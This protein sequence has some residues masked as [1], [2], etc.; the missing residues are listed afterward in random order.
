MHMARELAKMLIDAKGEID[1][2]K[3]FKAIQ[4]LE[5]NLYSLGTNRH[6]DGPFQ[7]HMLKI[8]QLFYS[9]P[10]SVNALKRICRPLNHPTAE[11]LIRETLVLQETAPLNDAHARQAA[12]SALLSRLRQNVG[13]CF[14]TAPAILIQQ[15]QPLR[16]LADIA[17]LFGTGRLNRIFE[18][19][20][21]AV[22]LSVSSGVGDLFR[23]LFLTTLGKNPFK[24]LSLSLGLQAA[25]ESAGLID[26]KV[27]YASKQK[28]CEALLKSAHFARFEEDPFS[29]ITVDGILKAVLQKNF[30]INE[31]DIAHYQEKFIQGPF[32][33]VVIQA[34]LT[35]SGKSLACSRY[36]K[37]YDAAKWAFKAL[38]DN[39][40]LKAW[41]FS[42][43][44]LSESKADF[45]KWNLYISLGVQPEDL[46]GIG[47]SLYEVI[48]GKIQE[49]NEELNEI[50]SRYD[51]LF[52]QAKYLEGRISRSTSDRE[53]GW[54]QAEYQI[55]RHEINRAL[56]ERDTIYEKGRKLQGLYPL[57]IEFYGQKIRDYFQ[58]VYDAE[59]HDISA[60]PYDDSPAGFR[61]VYKH[62]R[63][64]TALWTMIH[65]PAE[66]I[67]Y[68]T[69]FFVSTEIELNQ[70]PQFGGLQKEISELVTAAIMT[71]KRPEFLQSSIFR[72]SKAYNEP[73]LQNPFENLD[74]VKRKPWSY[75]SGGT[76][77][78]L[79]SCY[80]NSAQKP[81]EKKRWVEN[82]TEL[83]AFL[84]DSMKESSLSVQKKYLAE[85]EL[86]ML[87]FSPTHAFLVKPGWLLFRQA[88]ESDIYTY[89]WIRDHLVIPQQRFLDTIVLDN[90][91]METLIHELLAFIPVGYL[92]VVKKAF[93]SFSYSMTPPEFREYVMAR[94]SYEKWLHGSS[95]LDLVSEE[96][97]SIL[98]RKLP[99]FHEYELLERL[100]KVF[101]AME[102]IDAALKEKIMHFYP[103]VVESVGKYHILTAEDLKNIAKG[104]LILALQNTR[105][106]IFYHQKITAAMQK[107]GLSYPEPLLFADTNWVNN[108]FGFTVNPGTR[109][110]QL[111][112]FDECGSDGRPISQWKR[113]VNGVSH[114]EWGLY[115]SPHQYGQ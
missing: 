25:F 110:L 113:Y 57:L 84:I 17:Q 54:I 61:L 63:A 108:V 16:F 14:A 45:A 72:L 8:L 79:V 35:Q 22:P 48:Q 74:K 30:E 64:N 36:L 29:P 7:Q 115:T 44:S 68:L 12:F 69:S 3:L 76:M 93:E 91:M 97:D 23:P 42:L 13:S 85:Q 10:E 49:L 38:T 89:T 67:Q 24:T 5:K 107:V 56:S 18:G 6:H 92:P 53:A 40:L 101:D 109:E 78:T 19:V 111:W 71:I 98:Y 87:A 31:L 60:N 103:V 66:Y 33:D 82:E 86:N 65:S 77:S 1:R 21:Y 96:L 99:C 106:P 105:S 47:H 37:A 95:R 39:A 46:Y 26:S 112:R 100:N 104:L 73:L 32:A 83:L 9:N 4:L 2:R 59:M 11:R 51:H 55:R 41:E 80:W 50:Q 62:G 88:W 90:R 20:E 114:E 58:E 52:A 70:L 75:V 102:E 15:D 43:A 94:L 28:A 27:S 34:P 81:D